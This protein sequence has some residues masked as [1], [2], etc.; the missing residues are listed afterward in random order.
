MDDNDVIMRA[1]I[2]KIEDV[3]R[4]FDSISSN[5]TETIIL[6]LILI[7]SIVGI[8]LKS[9]LRETA[10]KDA[11][12]G[13][14]EK[15]QATDTSIGKIHTGRQR[16]AI[17]VHKATLTYSG[18]SKTVVNDLLKSLNLK[19]RELA[20]LLKTLDEKD[21][22]V[23]DRDVK[24][25]ELAQKYK[26]LEKRLAQRSAGNEYVA[27]AK[28]KLE[29]GDLEDA[30]KFLLQSLEKNLKEVSENKEAAAADAF[31]LGSVKELQLYHA[32]A[33]QFYKQAVQLEPDNTDYLTYF[34][35]FLANLGQ[36]KEAVKHYEKALAIDLSIYGDQHPDVAIRYNN[37]GGIWG[38]LGEYQKA[39]DYY[40]KAHFIFTSVLGHD[41]PYAK[42]VKSNI[43]SN[44][45][46]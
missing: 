34:G 18:V 4:I 8:Y 27:Q 3:Q 38:R 32:G 24:F 35:L 33:E 28:Q 20:R 13:D 41:H 46:N 37:I 16:P 43:E 44:K 6:I 1:V 10:K 15:K 40:E 5:P 11:S 2:M 25:Q 23:E 17:T 9:Y 21:V 31:E 12:D 22:A 7:I 36:Y 26:E 39:M 45:K 19:D 14:A 42:T 30:E 29:D